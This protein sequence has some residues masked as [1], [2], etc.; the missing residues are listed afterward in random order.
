MNASGLCVVLRL[1]GVPGR[2]RCAIL[3]RLCTLGPSISALPAYYR[4]RYD[5]RSKPT[6]TQHHTTQQSVTWTQ[7]LSNPHPSS[8]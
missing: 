1:G 5:K 8:F 6:L 3:T 7:T 2:D 4:D